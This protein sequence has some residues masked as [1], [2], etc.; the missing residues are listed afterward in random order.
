MLI[1]AL[2]NGHYDKKY[3]GASSEPKKIHFR[4]TVGSLAPRCPPLTSLVTGAQDLEDFGGEG[5][6]SDREG[7]PLLVT[8]MGLGGASPSATYPPSLGSGGE[9]PSPKGGP[10]DQTAK[11]GSPFQGSVYYHFLP[12]GS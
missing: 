10:Q 9:V 6:S 11:P 4:A 3:Q 5:W 8:V 12:S 7:I 2:G 1:I